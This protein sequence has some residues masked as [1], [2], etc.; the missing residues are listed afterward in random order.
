L[1]LKSHSSEEGDAPLHPI[2]AALS[3]VL[4]Y[5]ED[6][7]N[8]KRSHPGLKGHSLYDPKA[9]FPEDLSHVLPSADR[10]WEELGAQ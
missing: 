3:I 9:E 8:I 2:L 4:H 6:L 10:W 5:D 7:G 1:E